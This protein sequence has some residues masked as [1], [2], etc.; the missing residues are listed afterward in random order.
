MP[1]AIYIPRMLRFYTKCIQEKS[2]ANP[3]IIYNLL[4]SSAKLITCCPTS[5]NEFDSPFIKDLNKDFFD[6]ITLLVPPLLKE[7]DFTNGKLP[8]FILH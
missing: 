7:I 2:M 1:I 4:K 8:I 5:M 3:D 6:L